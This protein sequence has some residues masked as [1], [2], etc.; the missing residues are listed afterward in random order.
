MNILVW[1]CTFYKQDD[2]GNAVLNKNG[3]VQIYNAPDMDYS[4][5]AES[6]EEEDLEEVSND[7]NKN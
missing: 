1:D 4:D 3:N 7:T 2:D 6:V 5:L